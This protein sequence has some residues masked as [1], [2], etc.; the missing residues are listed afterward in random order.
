M[1]RHTLPDGERLFVPHPQCRVASG[2]CLTVG[3]CLDN[4]K[5]QTMREL[6]QRVKVL[7]HEL[8]QLR[9]EVFQQRRRPS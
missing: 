3:R 5:R 8:A 4:C 9:I 2:E 1:P 7:E 6:E